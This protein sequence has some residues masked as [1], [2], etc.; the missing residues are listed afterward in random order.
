M[1]FAIACR[2]LLAVVASTACFRYAEEIRPIT[3]EDCG[4]EPPSRAFLRMVPDSSGGSTISGHVL[5]ADAESSVP[6]RVGSALLTIVG[7]N[8]GAYTDSLGHFRIDSI[9]PG[10]YALRTRRLGYKPRQDS[11][12]LTESFGQIIDV[13]LA[14]QGHDGCPGFM[15]LVTRKRTWRW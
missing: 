9:A 6:T 11:V 15:A 7:T 4:P 13:G 5:D 12:V 3:A 10:R 1:R 8:R 14:R 2:I